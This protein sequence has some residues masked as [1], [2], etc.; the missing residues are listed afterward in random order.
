MS[1]EIV[2]IDI[3]SDFISKSK[4]DIFSEKVLC[5]I[6]LHFD[7]RENELKHCIKS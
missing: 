7:L 3:Q 1:K 2:T 4:Y 6:D 5:S